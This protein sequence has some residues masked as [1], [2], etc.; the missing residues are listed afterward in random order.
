MVKH[1]K[2][3]PYQR[4]DIFPEVSLAFPKQVANPTSNKPA[5]ISKIQF[6]IISVFRYFGVGRDRD[7]FL[8]PIFYQKRLAS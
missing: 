1:T 6:K 4:K 8:N 7:W 5:I 2:N 3:P